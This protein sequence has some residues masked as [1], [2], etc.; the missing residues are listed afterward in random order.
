MVIVLPDHFC[1][2]LPHF[3]YINYMSSKRKDVRKRQRVRRVCFTVNNPTEESHLSLVDLVENGT[4]RFLIYSEEKGAN[5]TVHL[6]GYAEFEGCFDFSVIK[7][8]MPLG[9]HIEQ[10]KGSKRDN[11]RYCSKASSHVS[12]PFIYGDLASH[13]GQRTDLY[14]AI[15]K[16]GSSSSVEKCA[17]DDTFATTY[18]KYSSGFD[19]LARLRKVPYYEPAEAEEKKVHVLWG[20]T[21]TGKSH[22]AY[23]SLRASY[24][25]EKPYFL[26]D[27]SGQWF[28]GYSG[29]SG[30]IMDDFR[31]HNSGMKVETFL[32]LT[33]KWPMDVPVKGSF[34]PWTP[35]TIYITSNEDPDL[36]FRNESLST[37]AAVARRLSTVTHLE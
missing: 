4:F 27:L 16:L 20:S 7:G 35:K 1:S 14:D 9:A 15:S 8:F 6:Q 37:Q 22:G 26:C 11:V 30:V 33:D 5:Q 24:P 13:Q 23:N 19:K 28:D 3:A 29:Q 10:A 31:G 2:L 21:G 36:W 12:G 18:V 25:L 17:S 32:R 34:V